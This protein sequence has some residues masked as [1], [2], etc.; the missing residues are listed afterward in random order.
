MKGLCIDTILQIVRIRAS[1]GNNESLQLSCPQ[2]NWPQLGDNAEV[3]K[4]L[5]CI[6]VK[7][8]AKTTMCARHVAQHRNHP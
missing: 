7:R 6:P 8:T 5:P 2:I 3:H 1:C 4:I